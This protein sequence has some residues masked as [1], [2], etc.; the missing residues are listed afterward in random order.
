M[1]ARAL[2]SSREPEEWINATERAREAR[3]VV[4]GQMADLLTGM[5]ITGGRE[6]VTSR[7]RQLREAELS[8]DASVVRA[9]VM[10]CAV[11]FGAW[12]VRIDLRQPLDVPKSKQSPRA[13]AKAAAG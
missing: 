10:E 4:A 13:R 6:L 8:G 12:A 2:G 5:D 1:G 3:S 7:I 11:A 9:A